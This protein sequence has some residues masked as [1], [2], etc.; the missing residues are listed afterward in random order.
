LEGEVVVQTYTPHHPAI[1]YARHHDYEGYA[2]HELSLRRHFLHPPFAHL[3]L[4]TSRSTHRERAE[5]SLKTL[6]TR[7]TQNVPPGVVVTGPR[8][9]PLATSHDPRRLQIVLRS[10]GARLLARHTREPLK[11]LTFPDDVFV[12]VDIDP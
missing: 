7:L 11:D 12:T 4:I 6:H 9:S 8:P 10:P 1:Q 5:F 3:A 2:E